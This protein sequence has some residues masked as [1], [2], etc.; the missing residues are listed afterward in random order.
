MCVGCLHL[1]AQSAVSA[2]SNTTE[3]LSDGSLAMD[4]GIKD[5]AAAKDPEQAGQSVA[6]AGTSVEE[7]GEHSFHHIHTILTVT[8]FGSMSNVLI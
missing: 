1:Q 6:P 4:L 7:A 8:I 3:A 5:H 2:S